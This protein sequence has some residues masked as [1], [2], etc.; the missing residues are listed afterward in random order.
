M[1]VAHFG[2]SSDSLREHLLGF[3]VAGLASEELAVHQISGNVIGMAL[4][5]RSKMSVG[6][7]KV[8]RVHAL[9]G[10]PVTRERVIGLFGEE[11]F[12]HLATGF[13]LFRHWVVSYYTDTIG[14]VQDCAGA[15][16][17]N[18]AKK[19]NHAKA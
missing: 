9:Q 7:G 10:K 11:L 6:G 4:Q 2:G 17:A 3:A 5:E 15:R 1:F 12:K 13:L 16:G 18:E 8:A 14:G 19:R